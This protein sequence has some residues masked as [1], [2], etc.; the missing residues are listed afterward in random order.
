MA[1]R[2]AMLRRAVR[3]EIIR[4]HVDSSLLD[5][6]VVNGVAYLGGKLK[7]LRT[8]PLN[9]KEEM[10]IIIQILQHLPGIKDVVNELKFDLP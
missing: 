6:R 3:R 5:V 2:D 8:E 1:L 9:L 10:E 7:C 4:R